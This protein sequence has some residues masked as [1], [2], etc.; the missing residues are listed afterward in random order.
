MQRRSGGVLH[1]ASD[2]VNFLECGHLTRLDL[3]ALSGD[4]T[5]PRSRD[6]AADLIARKGEEH[7]AAYLVSLE[8]AGKD[9]AKIPTFDEG[10]ELEDA[11]A[12]TRA[13]MAE[14]REI[15]FQGALL[16]EPFRGYADFLERVE[17]PSD[18]GPWSYEVADTKLARRVKPYFLIQLCLY[19]ELIASIQGLVPERMHIV[20]GT[21]DRES[22]RLADYSAYYRRV[23]DR[24]LEHVTS[25][26]DDTYPEPVEHCD[27]C[28][29]QAH[30]VERREADD[31]L[32]LVAGI[33]RSQIARLREREIATVAQLGAADRTA[34]PIRIGEHTFERLRQQARLQ[35][36]PAENGKP[37]LEL[38][39]PAAGRGFALL[40]PPS[41]GDLFFD[42]EG[43]PFYENGLEYL[44][45]VTSVEH[46]EPVFHAFWGRDRAEEKRAFEDF[47]D[48]VQERRRAHP[49]LHV[50]H[51]AHYEP[52]ALKRLMGM[53]A[54]REDDV[55]D[56]LRN[57]VLVDLYRVVEQSLRIGQPSYSIKKVEAF[58]MPEREEAVTDA[59]DSIIR[60]EQWLDSDPRDD[61]I[62]EEIRAYNEADCH[63][64]HL[65]REWLLER[66]SDAE[67]RFD[68]EVPW[69]P[70][71]DPHVP[72]ADAAAELD[73]LQRQLIAGLPADPSDRDP[74][75]R[76]L[77]L[78]AHLLDYH[79]RE[80]KPQWWEYFRRLEATDEE[81]TDLDA[82]A[83]GRL[84]D[85]GVE[86]WPLPRP[87]QSLVYTLSFPPQEHKIV[88][89]NWTD[90]HTQSGVTVREVDEST[91]RIEISRATR[92]GT[93]PL[94]RALIPGG[95]YGTDAQIAAL[96]RI[97]DDVAAHGLGAPGRYSALRDLLRRTPPRT[98]AV[99]LGEPLQGERFGLDQ[100]KAVVHGL[101]GSY[102]F[103]QGP[104]GSG[105]T[106][107]GAHLILDLI[108]AGK[109]VG[110]TS[111]SHKAIHNLLD[112][113][114]EVARE[115]G[116]QFRGLK[117]H[118]KTED[119]FESKLGD[120]ALIAA[121]GSNADMLDRELQLVAGTAWLFAR[122]DM[123]RTVDYLFI[124]EAGQ[125]SL[126]DT[127]AV[128]AA[129][130][131]LVLLGDPSQLAQVSQAVH[132]PGAGCSS[133]E[134]LLDGHGGT[135]PRDRGLF[136]DETHRMHPDVCRFIS[137]AIYEG[138]LSSFTNCANQRIDSPGPLTGT[139]VR[140]LPVEHTGNARRSEQEAAVIAARV[141]EL[142]GADYTKANG[143]TVPLGT[144]DI[145]VVSPYNAQVRCLSQSLPDGVRV[146]TVDKFQG[147][148][149]AVVFFSMATSTGEDIPRNLEFLFSRNRLNVAISRARCLA[150]LV[151][152]PELLH[153]RCRSADQMRL[154]NALCLLIE[155]AEADQR[156]DRP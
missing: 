69:R 51:Y 122:D 34:R 155:L 56:L 85:T 117:K 7:E 146:G 136:I 124:D 27:V 76:S 35:R 137:E 6:D 62:L 106:H 71:P 101:Q 90:P 131:N 38:L 113:V 78:L 37:P 26:L 104:P 118:S 46:G 150:V 54:T 44:F 45:G 4:A 11:V 135:V 82:D 97:A 140:Y 121:T 74:D 114:E 20:L 63:S 120:G 67:Q 141:D 13:A 126:A 41:E 47:V 59:G 40:P 75:Q 107:T 152:S 123:D 128:G 49:N 130:S 99:D 29:W 24:Y 43:D 151:C 148:Q 79:R 66:K 81:L 32:S 145:M 65:L 112:K 100:A 36:T 2:L 48:F 127:L 19:S 72:D 119:R 80:A 95:P 153:I 138:R 73:T 10:I 15:I 149:A 30:C 53:H 103:I 83:L 98:S 133:L 84:E 93:E 33:R 115:L 125:L 50:Y 64:T 111:N 89:G 28:H 147:Q 39:E 55:D 96:R 25:T 143:E 88:P 70:A 17:Q 154:V 134:H 18:L 102:L 108:Q 92:R 52:T 57:E 12:L 60:F 23:R 9:V 21:R 116:I 1:A 16:S 31:H 110:I 86:P 144:E 142:I 8:T 94:P 109:R 91:G 22:F 132:P 3:A 77:W 61:G 87:A 58:Y 5:I 14:G 105:K 42:M 68:L 139:G 156:G 129:S